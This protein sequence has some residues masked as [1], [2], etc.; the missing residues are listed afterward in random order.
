MS[1]SSLARMAPAS[2]S[3]PK[4]TST[5]ASARA[6]SPALRHANATRDIS[7]TRARPS[8]PARD[9]LPEGQR[10]FAELRRPGV[11]E[12]LEAQPHG[13]DGGL[14]RPGDIVGV[15]P[16]MR[17]PHARARWPAGSTPG[18]RHIGCDTVRARREGI[19]RRRLLARAHGGNRTL[20]RHDDEARLHG[21]AQWGLQLLI[22][23][24]GDPC[25]AGHGRPARRRPRGSGHLLRRGFQRVV[26]A[27]QHLAQRPRHR[28]LV[29]QREQLLDEERDPSLLS[30]SR[31]ASA[32]SGTA[33][34]MSWAWARTSRALSRWS[35][36][37]WI[38]GCGR[39]GEKP[40]QRVAL[41]R[42][43]RCG[44]TAHSSR[45]PH[46]ARASR[47]AARRASPHRPSAGP[48]P[49]R[50]GSLR[51]Q[52]LQEYRDDLVEAVKAALP[53]AEVR[54]VVQESNTAP[55]RRPP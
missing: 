53:R 54:T 34:R 5:V 39:V 10:A 42:R 48:R 37:R 22:R 16:M 24:L 19:R 47:T 43:R 30:K 26:P 33:P 28:P 38:A 14:E 17:D 49:I 23:H 51:A 7:C 20:A 25:S 1:R 40:P 8:V 45:R 46:A 9:A 3:G 55:A 18:T 11:G 50:R 13:D 15:E 21:R 44:R 29:V 36:R 31:R 41:A 35:E 27:E 32:G 6:G 4:G 52:R 2:A 12:R